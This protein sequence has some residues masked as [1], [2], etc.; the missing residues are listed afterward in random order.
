MKRPNKFVVFLK[1]LKLFILKILDEGLVKDAANLTF[2]SIVAIIPMLSFAL[3]ILP[4]ILD[5]DKGVY[6]GKILNNFIPETADKVRDL[7]MIA[8]SKKVSLNLYSFIFVGVGSFSM[9]NILN[10]TFDRILG[11]EHTHKLDIFTKITKFIGSIFFGFIIMILIFT[12]VSTTVVR[13]IPIISKF[14]TIISYFIPIILQFTILIILYLFLPSIRLSKN[15]LLKG[16]LITTLAWYIAK[17]GFDIYVGR[18]N[19]FSDTLGVLNTIP[20]A[21]FWLYLNWL[22]ILCGILI[23]A[24]F[25]KSSYGESIELRNN[26]EY[27]QLQLDVRIL[28]D[29]KE[30]KEIKSNLKQSQIGSI[31]DVVKSAISYESETLEEDYGEDDVDYDDEYMD[32]D[33]NDIYYE[34]DELDNGDK[35]E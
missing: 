1:T 26:Q 11:V 6:I 9:F 31:L 17:F 12:I 29:G 21:V 14:A 18:S 35:N 20:I 28:L 27:H 5:I 24:M 25:R 32:Y 22:I 8:L 34:E 10:K 23:I 7:I 15:D 13:D 30:Y 16:T 4:N 19:K 3:L 33:V 2:I